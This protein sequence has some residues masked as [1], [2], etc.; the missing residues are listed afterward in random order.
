MDKNREDLSVH[1]YVASISRSRTLFYAVTRL[2]FE[3][4]LGFLFLTAAWGLVFLLNFPD[5]SHFKNSLPS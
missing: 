1:L 4:M 3:I 2:N 5:T